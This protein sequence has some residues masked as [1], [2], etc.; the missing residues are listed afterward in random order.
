MRRHPRLSVLLAVLFARLLA[1]PLM[2][3]ELLVT[4]RGLVSRCLPPP[5]PRTTVMVEHLRL[6]PLLS[7][8]CA[9]LCAPL[10]ATPRR[11]PRLPRLRVL[12]LLAERQ[13][14]AARPTRRS[15]PGPPRLAVRRHRRSAL[16]GPPHLPARR[17]RRRRRP[18]RRPLR[19]HPRRRGRPHW[20]VPSIS[21]RVRCACSW[22][23]F[24]RTLITSWR[25][26]VTSLSR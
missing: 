22:W 2:A 12:V 19:R 11:L 14:L 9:T 8:S 24:L 4:A 23:R 6:A 7:P 16:H 17:R 5:L 3:R 18:L 13:L 10:A 15:S 1:L 20:Q 21:A 26:F 25:L